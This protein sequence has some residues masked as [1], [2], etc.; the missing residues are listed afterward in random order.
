MKSSV[1]KGNKSKRGSM[2]QFTS[3]LKALGYENVPEESDAISETY[4]KHTEG[5]ERTF[6]FFYNGSEKHIAIA[7]RHAL[8]DGSWSEITVI[9]IIPEELDAINEFC[10]EKSF[11]KDVQ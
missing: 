11:G 8:S 3:K 10:R 7:E 4:V 5:L 1:K 9:D 2:K 6:V